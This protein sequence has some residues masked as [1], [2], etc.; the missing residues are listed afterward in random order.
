[1]HKVRL[2]G[3]IGQHQIIFGNPYQTITLTHNTISRNAFGKGA[4]RAAHWIRGKKGF[5][6][7]EDMIGIQ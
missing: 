1:M 2:G 7:M 5:Y 4:I 6:T 3:I